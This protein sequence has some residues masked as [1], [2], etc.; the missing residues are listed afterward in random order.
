MTSIIVTSTTSMEVETCLCAML[1]VAL[2]LV[3][4]ICLALL[5]V[6]QVKQCHLGYPRHADANGASCG[7]VARPVL[8][9]S[10]ALDNLTVNS[11][12]AHLLCVPA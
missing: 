8:K 12:G 11:A 5:L 1:K 9:E 10:D 4:V 6:S 2:T 3:I 7:P